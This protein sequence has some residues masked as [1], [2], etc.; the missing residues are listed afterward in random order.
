APAFGSE[1]LLFVSSRRPTRS[2][3]GG[4]RLV[5][6]S[7]RCPRVLALES[8][9]RFFQAIGGPSFSLCPLSAP[10]AFSFRSSVGAD[11]ASLRADPNAE[12]PGWSS[13]TPGR[14]A[15]GPSRRVLGT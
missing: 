6:L 12:A 8:V 14:R 3:V 15:L 5:R 10:P 1:S 11:G 7:P 9:G 13:D 2:V 4:D